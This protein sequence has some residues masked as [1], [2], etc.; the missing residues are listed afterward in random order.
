MFKMNKEAIALIEYFLVCAVSAFLVIRIFLGLTGF[1]QLGGNG[2]HIAHM[3]W[4]GL[5][6]LIA[7][8]ISLCFSDKKSKHFVAIIGGIGFGTFIDEIGKFLTSDNNYFFQPAIAIIYVIFVLIFLFTRYLSRYDSKEE[9]V[10]NF[11][12]HK[13]SWVSEFYKKTI[14]NKI[15]SRLII[16]YF[17]VKTLFYFGIALIF[18]IQPKF[19]LT[20]VQV[21]IVFSTIGL[22]GIFVLNGLFFYFRKQKIECY[23]SLLIANLISIF[24][25]QVYQFVN[26]Q[27]FALT[28]LGFSLIIYSILNTKIIGEKHKD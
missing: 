8:L 17:I 5:L 23:K 2:L 24:I 21:L 6:M 4:G 1:P 11:F 3:L 15:V 13:I 16:I 7:I 9:H 20:H 10:D 19:L 22:I 18:F 27:L 25:F 26:D 12:G 28:D 14:L